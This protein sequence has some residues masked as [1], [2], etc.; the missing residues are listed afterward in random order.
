MSR[1]SR[2]VDPASGANFTWKRGAAGSKPAERRKSNEV[3]IGELS[4]IGAT[5]RRIWVVPERSARQ[6]KPADQAMI[7]RFFA[8][9]GGQVHD[10]SDV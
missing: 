8:G 9:P 1:P 10:S 5:S 7:D 2:A 3:R 4:R 6:M